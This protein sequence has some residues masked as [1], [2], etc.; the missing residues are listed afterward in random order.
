MKPI[1]INVS[2]YP[3]LQERENPKVTSSQEAFRYILKIWNMDTLHLK[4]EIKV[5]YLNRSNRILGFHNLSVGGINSCTVDCKLIFGIGLRCAASGFI[6]VHNHPS[7]TKEPSKED[8]IL[9]K[10]LQ[11]LG[12][13]LDLHLIDHL[14][15]SS[16]EEYVSMM[17]KNYL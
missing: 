16:K 6:L 1:E 11:D 2:Y 15:I 8:I 9:T 10:K 17:E 7:G 13:K 14:I 4:E 5:I 12:K 3:K